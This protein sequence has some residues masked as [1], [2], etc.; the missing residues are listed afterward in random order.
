M[1]GVII[2]TIIVIIMITPIIMKKRK[3]G[4]KM[5]DIHSHILPAVDDGSKDMF[6]SIE[7][8]RLYLDNGINKVIATPHY[9]EGFT[10]A[11]RD[12]N[13]ETLEN[14]RNTLEENNLD[15]EVYL[16]NEVYITLKIFNYIEKKV[17]STLNDSRYILIEFPM[18][19]IP[20]D[21]ENIIYELL[22]KGYIPVIAHPERNAKIIEDPNILYNFLMKGALAQLNLPSLEGRY[23]DK[24]KTVGELLL[25]HNMIHFVGTDAH[26]KNR[27]SPKVGKGLEILKSIVDEDKYNEIT[28][29]NG[30]KVLN[31]EEIKV[32]P[33]IKYEEDR[34]FLKLLKTVFEF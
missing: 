32:D 24:I 22:L 25:R 1:V 18:F 11:N 30:L 27:R 26:S 13:L 21:S 29:N 14:L 9:I 10:N 5:I 28:F 23:G 3:R 31:N 12:K 7:M 19:D 2:N 8:A 34:S 4:S 20:L 17:V 15:L 16:G 6:E 33:P